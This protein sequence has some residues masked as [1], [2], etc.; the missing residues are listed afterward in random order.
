MHAL[1][2]CVIISILS[3]LP[4]FFFSFLF[5]IFLPL[6]LVCISFIVHWCEEGL[7]WENW[8]KR[9]G[10]GQEE[11]RIPC[12]DSWGVGPGT[13]SIVSALGQTQWESYKESVWV[14]RHLVV[15]V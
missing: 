13:I 1:S 5:T 4:G 3:F 6:E 10:E 14:C 12:L 9:R 7:L 15:V 11:G 8:W 2:L